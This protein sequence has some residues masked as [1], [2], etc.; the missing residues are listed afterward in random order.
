M[1]NLSKSC[2]NKKNSLS[3]L[4]CP[5]DLYD[6]EYTTEFTSAEDWSIYAQ[7]F[8]ILMDK[9]TKP[10]SKVLVAHLLKGES[11]TQ[12]QKSTKLKRPEIISNIKSLKEKMERY[13]GKDNE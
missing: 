4:Y 13:L 5:E 8:K 11:I 3:K 6:S 2:Q 12:M 9:M 1:G 10:E 7:Q